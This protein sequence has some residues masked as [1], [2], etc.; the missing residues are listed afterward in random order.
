MNALFRTY[1]AEG[2]DISDASVIE[3]ALSNAGLDGKALLE[4]TQS[5]QIKDGL[6]RNTDLA[7]SRGVF[8]V[9]RPARTPAG[10]GRAARGRAPRT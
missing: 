9:L 1:W 6:R 8:G 3:R 10:A 7:L 4:A 5:Q 2:E